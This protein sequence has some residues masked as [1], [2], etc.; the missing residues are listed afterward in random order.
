MHSELHVMITHRC[1]FLLVTRL[2]EY[3]LVLRF[4]V[5]S[6]TK[7]FLTLATLLWALYFHLSK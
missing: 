4:L 1:L 6:S 3:T 7:V 2:D 5:K